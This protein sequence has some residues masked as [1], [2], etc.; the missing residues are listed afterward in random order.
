MAECFAG[1]KIY[2][3]DTSQ[4][5]DTGHKADKVLEFDTFGPQNPMII[6][7]SHT[8]YDLE[9]EKDSVQIYFDEIRE[10]GGAE[11]YRKALQAQGF[12]GIILKGNT[13]NYYEDGTYDVYID[14]NIPEKEIP[15]T[16]NTGYDARVMANMN[17]IGSKV[18]D[19]CPVPIKGFV[20]VPGPK[21]KMKEMP[22]FDF[23]K[24]YAHSKTL[25]VSSQDSPCCELC[26]KSPIA[27][28]YYIQN[29]KEK[30]TMI[31][32]SECVKHFAGGTSGKENLRA[33]KINLAIMMDHDLG[34][35][36]KYVKE[37]FSKLRDIVY[38][39]KEREWN[40]S[41]L[42]PSVQFNNR[43]F[44]ALK[45]EDI[46]MLV[47]PKQ[48]EY[49]ER[50]FTGDDIKYYEQTL[51]TIYWKYLYDMIPVYGWQNQQDLIK[52]NYDSVESAEKKLLTWY[53]KNEHAGRMLLEKVLKILKVL[54]KYDENVL[55][56]DYLSAVNT[57]DPSDK[58]PEM[59][60]GGSLIKHNRFT[61]Y[62][63]MDRLYRKNSGKIT[64]NAHNHPA[65]VEGEKKSYWLYLQS[66]PKEALPVDKFYLRKADGSM[67]PVDK[68]RPDVK[69]VSAYVSTGEG[70]DDFKIETWTVSDFTIIK[71]SRLNTLSAGSKMANK[72]NDIM[73]IE[74]CDCA[75]NHG[76]GVHVEN[77]PFSE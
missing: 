59:A 28:F 68:W 64:G 48:I 2:D 10:A 35:M 8:E 7:S 32:G 4:Y 15:D 43:I 22:E 26:G 54:D 41:Y 36:A 76:W 70:V 71:D 1:L 5:E 65:P 51:Q 19:W 23:P 27:I 37:N 72:E 24:G 20:M 44:N 46:S 16:M 55:N 58:K 11:N 50:N 3:G 9:N 29:D 42:G 31:T 30:T 17:Y 40:S 18:E 21:G 62:K 38:G 49:S 73:E 75:K 47:D 52:R 69:W 25:Y 33:A 61:G 60:R 12:D 74:G 13:T 63:G 45:G 53:K 66:N 6:D 14:F 34:I 39:R 56:S 67:K 77:C 57:P